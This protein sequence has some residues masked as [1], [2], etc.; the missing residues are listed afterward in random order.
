MLFLGH[1]QLMIFLLIDVPGSFL[2]D[3]VIVDFY[4]IGAGASVVC[5]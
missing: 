1:V 2:L 4:A 5:S 3:S